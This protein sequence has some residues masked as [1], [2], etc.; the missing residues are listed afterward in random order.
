MSPRSSL[1][2]LLELE[3]LRQFG[4]RLERVRKARGL[5]ASALAKQLDIAR[6]TLKAA[7]SGDPAVTM[8]TYMR[9]LSALGHSADLALLA[10]GATRATGASVAPARV[11]VRPAQLADSA[12]AARL[13][14][15]PAKRLRAP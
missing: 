10:A 15:S 14:P 13:L 7:E 4:A 1:T 3:L 11:K 5:S 9:V 6:N 12:R 8:G 2:S